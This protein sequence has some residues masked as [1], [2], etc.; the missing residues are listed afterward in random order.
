[1]PNDTPRRSGARASGSHVVEK[2]RPRSGEGAQ[3][4]QERLRG[5]PP[6]PA[7]GQGGPAGDDSA[8]R[9]QALDPRASFIVRAP[10]G[11]GK[12][13]LLIQRLLRL[14]SEADAPEEIA[15]I[16]FTRKAAAEMR[17]RLLAALRS[18]DAAAPAARDPGTWDLARAALSRC[19]R[20]VLSHPN[21]LRIQTI[22]A[23]CLGLARRHPWRSGLGGAPPA[24][25]DAEPLYREAA[26]AALGALETDTPEGAAAAHLLRHRDVR[27]DAVE[28]LLV[29]MLQRRDQWLRHLPA[30]GGDAG[31]LREALERTLERIVAD[32]LAA[33][34]G[35]AE[36]AARRVEGSAEG[37]DA[38]GARLARL[39]RHAAPH[40]GGALAGALAPMAAL[41][42]LPGEDPDSLGAWRAVRRLLLTDGGEWRKP[43]GVNVKLGFPA[44][45]RGTPEALLKDDFK[46]LLAALAPQ[47]EFRDALERVDRLPSPAYTDDQWE[48][49]QALVTV[50]RRSVGCLREQFAQSGSADFV[51]LAQ[52]AE[53]VAHEDRRDEIG[54]RHLLVDEFQD[55]SHGQFRLLERLTS[56]WRPGDGRT[57]FLVGDPMQSI[58][59]FREADVGLFLVAEEQG[60][61][62]L[63]L[64]P[65]RLERNFRSAAEIVEANNRTFAGVFPAR[66]DA[67][68]GAVPY[69]PAAAA[70]APAAP[71]SGRLPRGADSGAVQVHALAVPDDNGGDGAE[72]EGDLVAEIARA[73]LATDPSATVAILVQART[74]LTAI[75]PALGRAGV[76]I[77]AV[78]LDPL[79][80]RPAVLDALSLTRALL[81]SGDRIAWLSVLR[82]PWCGLG[83]GDVDVLAGHGGTLWQAVTAP[84][85]LAELTAAGR[86]RV[87]RVGQVLERACAE[88]GRRP[89][90]ETVE[91]AWLALGGPACIA[92]ADRDDVRATFA[93]IEEIEADGG[94]ASPEELSRRLSRKRSVPPAGT[95]PAVQV[96][97]IHEAKGLEFDTVIL[98]GLHRKTA[99]DTRPLLRWLEL[100]EAGR[101]GLVLAPIPE[102]GGEVEAIHRYLDEVERARAENERKRLLYVACTRARERLHLV[103][104]ARATSEGVKQ[105]RSGTLLAA[106][107]PV[108]QDRFA[109]AARLPGP[110]AP[111]PPA[112]GP[113]GAAEAAAA[114]SSPAGLRLTAAWTLPA[115]PSDLPARPDTLAAGLDESDEGESR[116]VYDWA[117]A[118]A[119]MVGKAVHALLQRI[120]QQGIGAW[121]GRA[122]SVREGARRLL[123]QEGLAEAAA[124]RASGIVLTAIEGCL[125]DPRGRWVLGPHPDARVEWELTL[126][127]GTR[128]R[129]IVLDRT[130]VDET[131]V[132]WVVDYK[133]GT[134]T[135]GGLES[136]L[137]E[138]Q[139]RYRPQLERYAQALRLQEPARS[140]RCG[141]YFPLMRGADGAGG[142]REWRFL[143]SGPGG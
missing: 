49:L 132:R 94:V 139:R 12:T 53:R 95:G 13:T 141:L 127:I 44:G 67:L 6:P 46:S 142:W 82:A 122:E 26:R 143:E 90:R 54:L 41:S 39:A 33:L 7:A 36:E 140:I 57:L 116:P 4:E 38:L 55:S 2:A 121:S 131:G 10:A 93:V 63:P 11:S 128:I 98:P 25:E 45:E 130:F 119:R 106:L 50:L 75:L 92:D 124:Q 51:E 1:M 5:D 105:P 104:V 24:R 58:Y 19:G 80:H 17:E 42:S 81:S 129:R 125:A 28:G 9:R 30:Q 97:T 91:K 115:L 133:T 73:A 69:A 138:E 87:G 65:L 78:A 114:A 77:Q 136:F 102:A 56:A 37:A 89:L 43:G 117:G 135:G 100:P 35:S 34:R 66:P 88:A 61:G 113:A 23:F 108:V 76:A 101:T 14:L 110:S 120:A 32:A 16:T 31:A 70:R 15:A 52:A 21:R 20:I 72:R 29:E 79:E 27:V 137:D 123:M 84:A 3:G 60:V 62:G 118:E 47:D 107:W 86:T 109:A 112:A 99:G 85:A 96:M 59:R 134:H 74:H 48:T 103:G 40:G 126:R 111:A 83:L 22:D 71:Q 18:G 8:I 64:Q 68:R